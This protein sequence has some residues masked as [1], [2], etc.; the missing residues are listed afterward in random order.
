MQSSSVIRSGAGFGIRLGARAIDWVYGMMIGFVTGGV[1]GGIFSVLAEM[2]RLPPDWPELLQQH[3]FVSVSFGLI[4]TFLYGAIAEGTGSITL[5]KL[6]CGLRVVQVNERPVTFQGAVVRNA[7]YFIDALFFGLV[8]YTAMSQTP[9]RQ[10]YG[11]KWAGT[12][13][14][15]A[16]VFQP[17]PKRSAWR[18]FVGLAL[19]SAFYAAAVFWSLWL[20]A[21]W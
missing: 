9:L 13:V 7:V 15:E 11:D 17:K 4:A 5:G 18:K 21:T 14:V 16:S 2:D 20:K 10:R 6:I 12:I 1:A 3:Q 8:G 19:G